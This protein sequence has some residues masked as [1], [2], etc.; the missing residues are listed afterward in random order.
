MK[1]EILPKIVKIL[2]ELIVFPFIFILGGLL[3]MNFSC[4]NARKISK[5]D[6]NI[7]DV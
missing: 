4:K 5:A 6:Q 7:V 1:F 2:F 3:I